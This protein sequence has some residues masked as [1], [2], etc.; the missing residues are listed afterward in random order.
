MCPLLHLI[1]LQVTRG[2]G[3]KGFALASPTTLLLFPNWSILLVTL[4]SGRVSK[5]LLSSINPKEIPH[6]SSQRHRVVGRGNADHH[7]LLLLGSPNSQRCIFVL[8]G[9]KQS[10]PIP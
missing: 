10:G 3:C 1:L 7:K 2:L 5:A 8:N 4:R 9:Q 6:A